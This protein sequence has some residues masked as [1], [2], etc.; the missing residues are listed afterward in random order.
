MKSRI[1][2]CCGHVIWKPGLKDPYVCRACEK[3]SEENPYLRYS[4][5][6]A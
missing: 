2:V 3:E 6:D 4:Y 1:C 5:L